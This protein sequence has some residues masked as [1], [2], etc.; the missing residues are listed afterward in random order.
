M[1]RR[2]FITVS[3]A[4]RLAVS[5]KRTTTS[6]AVSRSDKRFVARNDA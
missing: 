4:R 6:D 2:E 3:A 5:G 1:R